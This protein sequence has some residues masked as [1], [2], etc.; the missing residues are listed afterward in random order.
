[1]EAL[2]PVL[3]VFDKIEEVLAQSPMEDMP[4][5]NIFIRDETGKVVMFCRALYMRAGLRITSR[6]HNTEHPYSLMCGKARVWNPDTG[7]GIWQ[8]PCTGITKPGT[9]RLLEIIEDMIMITY[10]ATN[11]ETVQ[12]VADEILVDRPNELLNKPGLHQYVDLTKG[13]LVA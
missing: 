6:I 2:A 12:E 4:T 3:E 7:W 10:H 5:K 1:M 8:G 11:K 13:E 9:K